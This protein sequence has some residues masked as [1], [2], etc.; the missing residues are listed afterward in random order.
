MPLGMR[1]ELELEGHLPK[2]V[3]MIREDAQ[4]VDEAEQPIGKRALPERGQRRGMHVGGESPQC[5]QRRW[6]ADEEFVTSIVGRRP[7][8]I[9]VK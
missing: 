6:M 5:T 9:D 8:E 2:R 4:H 7:E 1:G 3:A